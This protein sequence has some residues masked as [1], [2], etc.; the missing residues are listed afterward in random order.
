M[1]R[2]EFLRAGCLSAC[3]LAIGGGILSSLSSCRTAVPVIKTQSNAGKISLPLASLQDGRPRIVRAA[4]LPHEIYLAP[5]PDGG[6]RALLM[7]CTHQDWELSINNT[8]FN[9]A[10]HGS[11]FDLEGN[12]TRG[13]ARFPMKKLT[14]R[15][16]GDNLII[17]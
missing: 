9:C 15:I 13:P 5:T 3:G 8:G 10:L 7:Q 14:A 4:N 6:W 17:S 11:T 1:S 12:V 16:E 2:K